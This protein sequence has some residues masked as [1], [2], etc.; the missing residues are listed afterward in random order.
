MRNLTFKKSFF[1]NNCYNT[2]NAIWIGAG[3]KEHQSN[4]VLPLHI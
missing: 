1:S 3:A 4:F 2:F